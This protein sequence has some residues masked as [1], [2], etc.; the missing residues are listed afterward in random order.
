MT[1]TSSPSGFAD[2]R[3]AAHAWA[4]DLIGLPWPER[5]RRIREDR[6]F[7]SPSFIELSISLG[8]DLCLS[9]SEREEWAQLAV[10]AAIRGPS[11]RSEELEPLAWAVLGNA[12]RVRGR[13][14]RS[15]AAFR[16]CHTLRYRSRLRMESAETLSLEASH[17]YA[18]A[19]RR[20]RR[21][22]MRHG[23]RRSDEALARAAEL[24]DEALRRATPTAA[25]SVIGR[26]EIKAGMIANEARPSRWPVAM[27]ML[28]SALDRIDPA[29]HPRLALSAADNL[30]RTAFYSGQLDSAMEG[31]VRMRNLY[32]LVSD[33]GLL[34]HRNWLVAD[35]AEARG[36]V[37]E[38]ERLLHAI[39]D[40]FVANGMGLGG[41]LAEIEIARLSGAAGRR[42]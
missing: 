39:R 33:P 24:I 31:V 10:E 30:A 6:A 27:T 22:E 23:D 12:Q 21:R 8:Q 16:C 7:A 40:G 34:L 3:L 9:P 14:A 20:A 18:I 37:N 4:A 25:D 5:L 35:I 11:R 38:A 28:L 17:W 1:D 26:Y 2:E 19:C 36:E 42:P 29:T 13:L 32:D 41:S 15:G